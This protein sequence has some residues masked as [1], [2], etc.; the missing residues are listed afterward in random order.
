MNLVDSLALIFDSKLNKDGVQSNIM[1][2]GSLIS[3]KRRASLV[4]EASLNVKRKRSITHPTDQPKIINR[5]PM[6]LRGSLSCGTIISPSRREELVK[7]AS[8]FIFDN[9]R[10]KTLGGFIY[11]PPVLTQEITDDEVESDIDETVSETPESS[12]VSLFDDTFEEDE[13]TEKSP[14]TKLM[15]R[16]HRSERS[17]SR[18]F[19][20]FNR[21][22]GGKPEGGEKN[23]SL[24]GSAFKRS[25]SVNFRKDKK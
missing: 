8:E 2:A 4:S 16:R 21:K 18:L 14:L 6:G 15:L 22:G 13:L 24:L 7:A 5:I 1:L 12:A 17:K 9:R 23:G 3:P 10:Q 20:F 25:R 11:Q 19:S